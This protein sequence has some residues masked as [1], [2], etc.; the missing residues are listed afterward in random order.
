MAVSASTVWEVR[1]TGTA[2]NVNGG[3]FVTGASG[4]DYS[5]QDASQYSGTN[6]ASANGTTNPSVITSAT[7]NFV[8]ADVGNIIRIS[9]GTNWTTGWYQIVSVAAN[10]AT[11]DR[12]V[13][14]AAGLSNGTFAVGGAISLNSATTDN[15][16][17]GAIAA[18]NTVWVKNGSLTIAQASTGAAG[19]A[20]QPI[21]MKGYNSSRGDNPTG[22]SRPT[23]ALGANTFTVG[24][25]WDV[26]NCIF[27]GTAAGIFSSASNGKVINCKFTNNSTTAARNC[28]VLGTNGY[29]FNCEAICYRGA[30][31]AFSTAA[32]VINCY[33]HDSDTGILNSGTTNASTITGNII[34]SNVTYAIRM[35]GANT[36]STWIAGNTLYGGENKTGTGL[37]MISG[38]TAI[39]FINNII[40]GFATGVSHAD[41]AQTICFDD[42]NDYFNNTADVS[43]WTKGSNDKALDPGFTSVAQKTGTTATTSGSVL[44]QSGADFSTVTDNRDFC[45]IVSGTGITAGQYLITSHTTTTLTLDIAPGTS[46]VADKV[47]KVTT[48]R[49]FSIGSNL[50]GQGFPGAFQAA[51]STSYTDMGA[52]QRK[53]LAYAKS[54]IVNAGG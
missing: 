8:A 36:G 45:Y 54:R 46:A 31:I 12:A 20:S 41:S 6:L 52:V 40:Y 32:Q 10:A 4:T 37:S 42:Y 34:E 11:L 24:N 23:L 27:T 49:D 39:R 26:Y 13:G 15:A 44:T 19:G 5:Q 29:A 2:G 28:L 9:A 18:G 14:T 16:F 51:L 17:F 33:I 38:N 47:F 21:M 43:G 22:S 1:S 53:N 35:A 3:G 7:H 50:R 25:N 48:G 30:A